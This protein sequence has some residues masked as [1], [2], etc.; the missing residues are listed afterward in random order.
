MP[1]T[2]HSLTYVKFLHLA[3]ALRQMPSLPVLDTVEEHLLNVFAS[4][5]HAGRQVAVMEATRMVPDL[6]ERT[7]FRRLKTLES[8]GLVRF[9]ENPRDHRV[10]YVLPTD[11]TEKYFHKLGECMEQARAR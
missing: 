5:W 10:R 3:N 2:K 9:G 4:A 6:S 7:V 11:Q 8:K 1:K